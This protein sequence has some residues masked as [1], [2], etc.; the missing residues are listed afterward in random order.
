M[1]ILS[2][3]IEKTLDAVRN[4]KKL[5]EKE[6]KVLESVLTKRANAIQVATRAFAAAIIMSS[7]EGDKLNKSKMKKLSV[8]LDTVVDAA[9][10]NDME[11]RQPFSENQRKKL[12]EI[13]NEM[14]LNG[15]H[16]AAKFMA[17]F[18]VLHGEVL[19]ENLTKVERR[20]EEIRVSADV[21]IRPIMP[22]EKEKE[23]GR[24]TDRR[25]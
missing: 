21:P 17:N 15:D 2:A 1:G 5:S 11:G 16:V 10:R 14:G 6:A 23:R 12:V 3:F 18:D 9:I 13:F 19:K 25:V 20:A 24:E 7:K 8:V 4:G 22:A